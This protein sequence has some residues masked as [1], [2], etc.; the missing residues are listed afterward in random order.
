MAN[1]V[2]A[3]VL[4]L[5]AATALERRRAQAALFVCFGKDSP[6]GTREEAFQAVFPEGMRIV[7]AAV[8]EA[9]GAN[10]GLEFRGPLPPVGSG[11][12]PGMFLEVQRILFYRGFAP[13]IPEGGFGPRSEEALKAFQ[14]IA[15]VA[16][17]GAVDGETL[18]LLRLSCMRS[19]GEPVP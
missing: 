4:M 2:R 13:G 5:Y 15:G 9:R 11:G 17:T 8:A 3:E 10:G 6:V 16:V 18:A 7:A 12:E 14:R 19:T 1:G